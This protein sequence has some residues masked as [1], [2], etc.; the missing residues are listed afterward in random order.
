MYKDKI[1]V[2]EAKENKPLSTLLSW[3]KTGNSSKRILTVGQDCLIYEKK[4]VLSRTCPCLL[5]Q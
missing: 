4:M 2:V 1:K 3:T 5:V